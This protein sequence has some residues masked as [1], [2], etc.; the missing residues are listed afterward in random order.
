MH[1]LFILLFAFN[2]LLTVGHLKCSV[3]NTP[4]ELW[5]YSKSY[6][7]LLSPSVLTTEAFI[8]PVSIARSVLPLNLSVNGN[9]K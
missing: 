4:W 2:F 5:E 9:I 7:L 6:G 3:Y 8:T 1:S